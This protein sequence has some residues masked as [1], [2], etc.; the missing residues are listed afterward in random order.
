MGCLFTVLTSI[1]RDMEITFPLKMKQLL[2]AVRD[3]LLGIGPY[4][5][6]HQHHHQFRPG[7]TV[8]ISD[9]SSISTSAGLS[10]IVQKTLMQ[11]IELHAANWQLP[12]SAVRYYYSSVGSGA[13]TGS[14]GKS[15]SSTSSMIN[16]SN[17]NNSSSISVPSVNSAGNNSVRTVTPRTVNANNMGNIGKANDEANPTPLNNM[18]TSSI[19]RHYSLSPKDSKK[20]N[21]NNNEDKKERED[22][23]DNNTV[24][25]K[26]G[27]AEKGIEFTDNKPTLFE[28]S[29]PIS[30]DSDSSM[31]ITV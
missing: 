16:V 22:A 8:A 4:H 27:F 12:A 7:G 5:Q 9:F 30:P 10:P 1:G 18:G 19:G 2:A 14:S 13:S 23:G 31:Y 28:D 21:Q 29:K 11:L 15:T 17:G 20:D 6:Q 26:D 3:A 25:E 24:K